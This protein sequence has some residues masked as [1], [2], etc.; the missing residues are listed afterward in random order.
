MPFMSRTNKFPY[1]L[2]NDKGSSSKIV[3]K[4]REHV[5]LGASKKLIDAY[6]LRNV[7]PG[8]NRTYGFSKKHS[9]SKVK[10]GGNSIKQ[11]RSDSHQQLNP[12]QKSEKQFKSKKSKSRFEKKELRSLQ[13]ASSSTKDCSGKTAEKITSSMLRET[14]LQR[15]LSPEKSDEFFGR[16]RANFMNFIEYS[17]DKED[18]DLAKCYNSLSRM[19]NSNSQMLAAAVKQSRAAS[20]HTNGFFSKKKSSTH[21]EKY[22]SAKDI[23]KLIKKGSLARNLTGLRSAEKFKGFIKKNLK[24]KINQFQRRRKTSVSRRDYE[25]YSKKELIGMLLE[26]DMEL[27]LFF[28]DQSNSKLNKTKSRKVLASRGRKKGSTNQNQSSKDGRDSAQER[29]SK[30]GR[31]DRRSMSCER[32]KKSKESS[33]MRQQAKASMIQKRRYSAS[34]RGNVNPFIRT[35]LDGIKESISLVLEMNKQLMAEWVAAEKRKKK[36]QK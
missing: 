16:R 33:A 12:Y 23:G 31:E 5:H 9:T 18:K 2:L 11:K 25:K 14:M 17:I 6:H 27:K 19:Q 7:K 24:E 22:R 26:K 4:M 20:K 28:E 34:D 35:K 3:K 36:V 21:K 29:T 1:S 13:K 32:S 15:S 10:G 8:Q 30:T